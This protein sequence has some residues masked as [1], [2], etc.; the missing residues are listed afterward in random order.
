[1]YTLKVHHSTH[2]DGRMKDR[3]IIN[4]DIKDY[5][6][7]SLMCLYKCELAVI[8]YWVGILANLNPTS[9]ICQRAAGLQ[10]GGIY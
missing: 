7:L 1:M 2:Q 6:G 8:I 3:D 5:T 10:R 4:L 9:E